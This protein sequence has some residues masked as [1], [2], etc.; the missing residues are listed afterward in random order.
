MKEQRPPHFQRRSLRGV[1]E[2]VTKIYG[3]REG[4]AT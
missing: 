4:S 2:S 3:K 1:R